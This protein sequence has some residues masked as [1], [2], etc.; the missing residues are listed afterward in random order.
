MRRLLAPLIRHPLAVLSLTLLWLLLQVSLAPAQILLGL[1]LAW[2]VTGV[3]SRYWAD[4][5]RPRRPHLL[6]LYLWRVAVDVVIANLRIAALILTPSRHPR[7][8]F[9]E[10]PLTLEEPFALYLLATTITLSPGSLSADLSDDRC[11][12]LLHLLDAP[13]P[14]DATAECAKIKHR[15]ERLLLEVFP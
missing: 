14:A 9:V 11:V 2:V 15:Y 6:A 10:L 13:Y 7:P 5:R 1:I 12:L 8:A 3:S 4:R